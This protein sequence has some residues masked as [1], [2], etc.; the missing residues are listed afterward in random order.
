MF[1]FGVFASLSFLLATSFTH[2]QVAKS[3]E[4]GFVSLFNGKNLDGWTGKAKYFRV[5]GGAIIAGTLKEKIP[6]NEFLT[7][8]GKFGDFELR[9]KARLV[10][11][12]GN[13]GIQIRSR[14]ATREE[15]ESTDKKKH[16]PAHEMY[17]YQV[18][19]GKAWEKVWWGKLYDESRRR[20]VLAGPYDEEKLES[21]VRANDWNDYRI[22]AKGK[23]IQIWLNGTQTVDF[24]EKEDGIAQSGLIGLQIHSGPPSEASYKDIRIKEIT[25]R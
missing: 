1:R 2:A 21:L 24:V 7:H 14:R 17:G 23:R 16:L 8:E 6:N 20:K 3:S 11:K 15:I 9:L 10:G 13:A 12:G 19:M 25:E 4:D 18:D 5:E 22:V